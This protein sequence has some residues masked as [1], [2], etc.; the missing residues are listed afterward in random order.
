MEERIAQVAAGAAHSVAVSWKGE[1]FTWGW[2]FMGTLGHG[3]DLDCFRPVRVTIPDYVVLPDIPAGAASTSRSA[4]STAGAGFNTTRAVGTPDS[5]QPTP[6][7]N[8]NAAGGVGTPGIT[9][10]PSGD[11]SDAH[12]T[13]S[14]LRSMLSTPGVVDTPGA[15]GAPGSRQSTPGA[16]DST[17]CVARRVNHRVTCAAATLD[18]TVLG[19][20]SGRVLISTLLDNPSVSTGVGLFEIGRLSG[21]LQCRRVEISQYVSPRARS[22]FVIDS[23]GHAHAFPVDGAKLK[24]SFASSHADEWWRCFG[25][26]MSVIGGSV[27]MSG[28]G[29]NMDYSGGNGDDIV[30]GGQAC[31]QKGGLHPDMALKTGLAMSSRLAMSL[32]KCS[33]IFVSPREIDFLDCSFCPDGMAGWGPFKS[34]VI[35]S[36]DGCLMTAD[37]NTN[38]VRGLRRRRGDGV[39]CAAIGVVAKEPYGLLVVDGGASLL[40]WGNVNAGQV[41]GRWLLQCAHRCTLRYE[42]TF[43]CPQG[44]WIEELSE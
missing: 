6:G 39:V 21:G 34:I 32:V 25:D 8:F 37:A 14:T 33:S 9:Q 42:G 12:G 19:T 3:N 5:P 41:R 30:G 20:S 15:T 38:G 43:F 4:Y 40:T 10:C 29:V 24:P 1:A 2:G 26:S 23:A 17:G 36:T 35:I 13:A 44:S 16:D 22:V 31:G 18:R 28:G 11:D 27:S 7:S